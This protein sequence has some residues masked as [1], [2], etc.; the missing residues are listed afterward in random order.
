[1]LAMCRSMDR[2]PEKTVSRKLGRLLCYIAG[3]RTTRSWYLSCWLSTLVAVVRGARR[4]TR[5]VWPC[6]PLP[7][8]ILLRGFAVRAYFPV[9]TKPYPAI[10]Y[11]GAQRRTHQ[12]NC[13]D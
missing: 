12:S 2:N 5:V 10:R 7:L 13:T 4:R 1:M 8:E 6:G 9:N 11:H 3:N